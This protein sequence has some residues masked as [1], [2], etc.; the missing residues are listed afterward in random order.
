MVE[1][2]CCPECGTHPLALRSIEQKGCDSLSGVAGPDVLSG[3]LR[4]GS[5]ERLYLIVEGIPRLLSERFAELLDL[6]VVERHPDAFDEVRDSLEALRTRSVEQSDDSDVSRWNLEDV[7]FWDG[8]VY[9]EEDRVERIFERVAIA[10]PDAGN[11]TFPR[12]RFLFRHLREGLAGGALL[13][14]GCGVAHTVRTLCHPAEV[15]YLYIGIE[16]S[17]SALRI[18]RRTLPGEFVQC[19]A[20]RL[21]FRAASVD[22]LLMLGTL[23][24][25]ADPQ[26]ALLSALNTVRPGGMVALDEVVARSGLVT[27][28]RWLRRFGGEE[29]AHNDQV[30]PELIRSCVAETADIE[31]WR[32]EY[33]PVRGLLVAPLADAMRT[34]PWLTR[35]VIA[36]DRVCIVTIGRLWG[37]F[38]GAELMLFARKR[39][40][41]DPAASRRAP[42]PYAAPAGSP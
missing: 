1:F 24:H 30:D 31:V 39:R 38:S 4:C 37:L 22:G 18:N 11:R 32:R 14:V 20:D 40:G 3:W 41:A 26:H 33:S 15:G 2:L 5:C 12:E 6:S 10:R 16:L 34:R 27:Q 42:R 8:Q 36:L 7:S 9:G 21:P 25:L 23:H 19:S 29:S 35:L 13:D 17:I 28:S